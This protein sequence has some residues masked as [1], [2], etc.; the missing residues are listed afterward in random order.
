MNIFKTNQDEESDQSSSFSNKFYQSA[1][2]ERLPEEEFN[3]SEND[4]ISFDHFFASNLNNNN[5]NLNSEYT[6]ISATFGDLW[7][8]L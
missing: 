8:F 6:N 5:I 2:N 1:N 3:L 7:I 4:E